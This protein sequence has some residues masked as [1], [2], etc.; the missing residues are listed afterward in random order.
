MRNA[1]TVDFEDWYQPFAARGV[2]GWERYPSR[3]PDDTRRLVDLLGRHG[4]CATFFVLGEVADRF[5]DAVRAIHRAGHEVASHGHRHVPLYAQTQHDFERETR[6]SLD[7][8]AQLTGEPVVGFRAPFFSVRRDSWWA[9]D[10]LRALG[11]EYDS[12]IHPTAGLLHGFRDGGRLPYTHPNGLR[13]FP[14]TTY[15]LGRVV[16]PFGG[17]VYYRLLPYAIIRRGLGRLNRRL[18]G[19]TIYL[20]PRELDADLP[21]LKVGWRLRL[22]VYAGTRSF[23]TKLERLLDDFS[24]VPIRALL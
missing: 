18:V 4:V 16:L 5:P 21:R 22:I 14:I 10:S 13:E 11:L 9:I 23:G 15:D 7:R 6:E 2:T 20:H 17:G 3:V 8:L 12:S 19:G 24:F 1:L